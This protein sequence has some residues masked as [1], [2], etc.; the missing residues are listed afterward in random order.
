[1]EFWLKKQAELNGARVFID[2][3]ENNVTFASA[4]TQASRLARVLS[5]L[6]KHRIGLYIDNSIESVILINAAWLAGIEIAMLNTRLT[7]SEMLAQMNSVDV[8]TIIAMN[9]LDLEDLNVMA[10]SDLLIQ[11][12]D[13]VFTAQFSINSIASIMFTSGTTGPQKAVP[14]TFMNHYASALGCKETLGFNQ[15]TKWLSVLP[16]YHISGLSVILRALIE[17]FTVRIESKFNADT[18]L[19]IIKQELPTHV[20]LVPQT[21]KWLMDTGMNQPFHI[22]KILLGGAKLSS[23]LIE[24]ALKYHLPIYNSF[25]MT[26]TCS[27]FLTASPDMLAQ[28]YDTVGKPSENVKVKIAKPNELGHGELL[29]K[30]DNVMKDY[31]YPENKRDTFEDGYF[32]TGDIAEIDAEGYVMVYDRRKDLIISGGENIYPYQIET[33]AKQYHSIEDAMC[34]GIKDEQW[35][36]VPC[37]YYI[38]NEIIPKT[39]L[40]KHF[41]DNIAKYKIP[42]RFERVSTL[43][44]TSTGKLQRS[45]MK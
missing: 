38:S 6:G 8:D 37:L 5:Q 30:G 7:K 13:E 21:L 9:E 23:S 22:E 11:V 45:R 43:P 44:Y 26:E 33:V 10:Y 4:Y 34:V 35:G 2:D 41:K 17:G 40:L 25:G 24:Q 31:L 12:N 16:I 19:A 29:I 36:E 39:E 1:M 42:K 14:Q 3:G 27:Q 32:K 18:M 15:S 20:S 28:R